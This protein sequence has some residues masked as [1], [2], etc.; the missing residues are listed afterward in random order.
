MKR[1]AAIALAVLV[2]CVTGSVVTREV[3]RPATAQGAP[4]WEY[5]CVEK[6]RPED[7]QEYA[8]KAG[9]A[10]WQLATAGGPGNSIWCFRQGL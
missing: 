3:S 9:A 1:H 5:I 6:T 7:I 4:K 10:G 8:N 2:G